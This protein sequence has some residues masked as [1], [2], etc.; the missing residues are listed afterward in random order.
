MKDTFFNE[1]VHLQK[2][3]NDYLEILANFGLIGYVLLL[4]LVYLIIIRVWKV[5]T[6]V[7]HKN[8]LLVLGLSLGLIGFSMVAL[9]SFPVR[10]YLPAF[11]VLVYFSLITLSVKPVSRFNLIRHKLNKNILVLI[12]LV[13]F[14]FSVFIVVMSN[15]WVLAEYHFSNAMAFKGLTMN[16]LQVKAGLRSLKYNNRS[17]RAYIITAEGLIR[18]GH[19]ET[20]ILYIKKAID[21][22]PFNSRALLVL[23]RIFDVLYRID[24]ICFY[25]ILLY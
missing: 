20:A 17:S 13:S 7:S 22:S 24:L 5:L 4:W 21:I 2:V 6:E 10:V 15:R 23:A 18:L 9:V 12:L 16:K 14:V 1:Q 3:H 19:V 25:S 11:L 8:R